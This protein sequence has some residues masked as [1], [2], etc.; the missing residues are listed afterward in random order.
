LQLKHMVYKSSTTQLLCQ[1]RTSIEWR[2]NKIHKIRNLTILAIR[3]PWSLPLPESRMHHWYRHPP[4]NRGLHHPRTYQTPRSP[5]LPA[6]LA[7]ASCADE[8][9]RSEGRPSQQ[10]AGWDATS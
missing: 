6:S 9:R 8:R 4:C 3:P 7:A 1:H 5:H 2:V 10:G